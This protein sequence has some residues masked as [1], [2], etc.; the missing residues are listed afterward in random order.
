[1]QKD[2]HYYGTYYVARLAGF[3]DNDARSIAWAAQTVDEMNH[4]TVADQVC[5][6]MNDKRIFLGD[7]NYESKIKSLIEDDYNL[8]SVTTDTEYLGFL[9]L[10]SFLDGGN[11]RNQRMIKYAWVPFHFLPISKKEREQCKFANLKCEDAGASINLEN[12]LIEQKK[13]ERIEDEIKMI[14]PQFL[15]SAEENRETL[16]LEQVNFFLR[17]VDAVFKGVN[18]EKY[19]LNTSDDAFLVCKTST[20]L[21]RDMIVQAKN[22]YQDEKISKQE[23]LYRIGISMHVLADTWSHQG[24]CGSNNMFI[25][26]VNIKG[27]ASS[28][29]AGK[30]RKPEDK[31][32]LEDDGVV[33]IGDYL[34]KSI[35]LSPA[36]TGHGS[37][38]CNPDIPGYK[39]IME[40]DNF[41]YSV[42]VDNVKRFENAFSQMYSALVFIK[43]GDKSQNFNFEKKANERLDKVKQTFLAEYD[44][45][46]RIKSWKDL[47]QQEFFSNISYSITTPTYQLECGESISKFMKAARKHRQY[48]MG[49]IDN[50]WEEYVDERFKFE[51]YGYCVLNSVFQTITNFVNQAFNSN[52]ELDITGTLNQIAAAYVYIRKYLLE[53]INKG[54]YDLSEDI[55]AYMGILLRYIEYKVS[56][57]LNKVKALLETVRNSGN[58]FIQE[59]IDAVNKVLA[60]MDDFVQN[61]LEKMIPYLDNIAKEVADATKKYLNPIK[62]TLEEMQN[63]MNK[64][65]GV[66][67][68]IADLLV[69]VA[70]EKIAEL[71]KLLQQAIE[72]GD[73]AAKEKLIAAKKWAEDVYEKGKNLTQD[74]LKKL[75]EVA[76]EV[77]QSINNYVDPIAQ[78]V[79]EKLESA[80]NKLKEMERQ[81]DKIYN[82]VC[83]APLGFC[84]KM[85]ETK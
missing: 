36:W 50:Q 1:M 69:S 21:C 52:N 23:R 4:D 64:K 6:S 76:D 29:D 19:K 20:Q 42:S 46:K 22:F 32:C 66:I 68:E 39:Y 2:C 8:V 41:D 85:E 16:S 59:R 11:D 31:I 71:D 84:E 81:L 74:Q 7:S 13:L 54:I 10:G 3:D 53:Y 60:K 45:E 14:L 78:S 35:P 44:V 82:V 43:N 72:A 67:K 62:N 18:G 77:K 38:G 63:V 5:K 17:G 37:A 57:E 83:D 28:N 79:K 27:C 56:Q 30:F 48:V 33:Y 15:Y 75:D 12:Y 61:V 34:N 58:K 65:I 24:F 73:E 80:A 47:I 40:Y 55:L 25:N 26:H 49:E 51:M 70:L 9:S